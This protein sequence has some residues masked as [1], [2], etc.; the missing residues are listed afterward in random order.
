MNFKHEPIRETG[1][2]EEAV[3]LICHVSGNN[4]SDTTVEHTSVK[5]TAEDLR[6]ADS[7]GAPI[8]ECGKGATTSDNSQAKESGKRLA[9]ATTDTVSALSISQ[10]AGT[11]KLSDVFK[12]IGQS[13][14]DIAAASSA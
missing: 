11:E 3:S 9:A 4:S 6:A 5:A 7:M 13:L 2:G 1:T 10:A 14:D 12:E 8:N